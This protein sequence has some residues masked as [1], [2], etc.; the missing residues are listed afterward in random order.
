VSQKTIL[1]VDD[2]E[3]MRALLHDLLTREGYRILV[4][5]STEAALAAIQAH[6]IDALLTDL[7]LA[8]RTGLELLRELRAAGHA[9]PIW[10]M[11]GTETR[12]LTEDLAASGAAGFVRKPFNPATLFAQ[13]AAVLER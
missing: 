13:L 4:S 7:H 11:S 6:P 12:D 3:F 8:G 2:S 9:F 10:V 1:V 5:D